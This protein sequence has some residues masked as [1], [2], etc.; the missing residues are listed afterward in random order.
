M[1]VLANYK[2]TKRVRV[3]VV[4]NSDTY[5]ANTLIARVMPNFAP[6]GSTN[7]LFQIK[8]Y[9]QSESQKK[10]EGSYTRIDIAKYM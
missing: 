5:L 1:K 7:D 10:L 3:R 6:Y 2:Q 9:F 4:V 8:G